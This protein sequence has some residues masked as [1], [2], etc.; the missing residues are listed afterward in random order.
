MF[1]NCMLSFFPLYLLIAAKSSVMFRNLGTLFQ[2][3]IVLGMLILV[4]AGSAVS[5]HTINPIQLQEIFVH[6]LQMQL[7]EIICKNVNAFFSGCPELC[8]HPLDGLDC[9]TKISYFLFNWICVLFCFFNFLVGQNFQKICKI[10]VCKKYLWENHMV[11]PNSR[12]E[13]R[14]LNNH[15]SFSSLKS[16]WRVHMYLVHCIVSPWLYSVAD[17]DTGS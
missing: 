2:R 4:F 1:I 9:S 3:N 15:S 14:Q 16:I 8:Q 5:I 11:F 10:I 6:P 13:Q 12:H 7:A 17:I